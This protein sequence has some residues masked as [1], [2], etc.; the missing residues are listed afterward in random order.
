MH[1]QLDTPGPCSVILSLCLRMVIRISPELA[2]PITW[3]QS[4][5]AHQNHLWGFF[6]IQ[7]SKPH[8]NLLDLLGEAPRLHVFLEHS[9]DDSDGLAG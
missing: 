5:G 3:S 8:I 7:V 9:I 2:V 6:K 4:I 1:G